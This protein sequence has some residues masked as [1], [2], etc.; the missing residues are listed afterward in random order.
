MTPSRG[1]STLQEAYY[2]W[3]VANG[4][5]EAELLRRGHIHSRP[6]ILTLQRCELHPA[7][8]V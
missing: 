4:D 5:L 3:T 6:A 1:C 2:L 8:F 7:P